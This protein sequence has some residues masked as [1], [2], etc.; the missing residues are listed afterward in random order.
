MR[1]TAAHGASITQAA[2]NGGPMIFARIGMMQA[3]NRDRP[4]VFDPDLTPPVFR[5]HRLTP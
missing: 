1:H 5:R 2:E 4:I 3:I